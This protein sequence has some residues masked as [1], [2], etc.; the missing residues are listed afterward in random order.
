MVKFNL[1]KTIEL[2]EI[3]KKKDRLAY[4]QLVDRFAVTEAEIE[5]F[6]KV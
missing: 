1:E 6:A 4:G 5:S 2:L 3:I